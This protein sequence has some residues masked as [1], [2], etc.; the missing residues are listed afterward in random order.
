MALLGCIQL[1]QL[2]E[3]LGPILLGL[4]PCQVGSQD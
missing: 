1:V 4:S 3:A 2:A